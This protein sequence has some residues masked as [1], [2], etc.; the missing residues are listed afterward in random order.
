MSQGAPDHSSGALTSPAGPACPP[1]WRGYRAEGSKNQKGPTRSTRAGPV[2]STRRGRARPSDTVP[3]GSAAG[4]RPSPTYFRASA[5][6]ICGRIGHRAACPDCHM[7]GKTATVLS[8]IEQTGQLDPF[9]PA[10]LV[11]V[12]ILADRPGGL[13]QSHRAFHVAEGLG[14][15]V[16]NECI[17][18]A[19]PV[20]AGGDR[21]GGVGGADHRRKNNQRRCV[22]ILWL[23]GTV[24]AIAD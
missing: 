22:R 16:R 12:L 6:P 2:R 15:P 10:S 1:S 14:R 20:D 24:L 21:R 18:C 9:Q 23:W 4:S 8:A 13:L 17:G 5:V 19:Q 11:D 3:G 7:L